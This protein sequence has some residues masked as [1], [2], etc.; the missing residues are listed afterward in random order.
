VKLVTS[1]ATARRKRGTGILP[2]TTRHHRQ[3]ADATFR[4]GG[5]GGGSVCQLKA[6]PRPVHVLRVGAGGALPEGGLAYSADPQPA[7]RPAESG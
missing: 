3:D 4:D 2:V 6:A 1:A 7:W 5:P